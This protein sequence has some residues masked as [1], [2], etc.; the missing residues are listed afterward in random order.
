MSRRSSRWLSWHSWAPAALSLATLV[1]CS[2]GDSQSDTTGEL[3]NPGAAG[4]SGAG[5]GSGGKS[6]GGG[7]PGG[8]GK[9]GGAGQGQ[10]GVGPAG[11]QAGAGQ[12][13]SGQAGSSQTGGQG[14]SGEAG[15]AQG[16]EGG[17]G[18][19]GSGEAGSGQAGSGQ[20]GSGQAGSGQAGSGQAGSGQAGS[21]QAGSGQAGSGQAGSGQAGG[22][23]CCATDADCAGPDPVVLICVQGACE[24]PA[25][26]GSCWQDAECGAGSYCEGETIC[27]CGALCDVADSPGK[28]VPVPDGCCKEDGECA[29]KGL[30]RCLANVCVPALA[31][32]T[33]WAADDCSA[34]QSCEGSTTCP[35][36]ANCVSNPG[37]CADP[38][39]PL[40][41]MTSNDC[42]GEASQCISGVC[43]SLPGAAGQC[44]DETNCGQGQLC[45]GAFICP[46]GADCVPGSDSLGTCVVPG[47]NCCKADAECKP[48]SVCV[49]NDCKPVAPAG[50][51]WGD[52]D[53]AAD[54]TCEGELP[55]ACGVDCKTDQPGKCTPATVDLC[56]KADADCTKQGLSQCVNSVCVGKLTPGTCWDS[57]D[58]KPAQTCTGAFV[59]PCGALCGPVADTPGK[60]T[61]GGALC[62]T[63]DKE[64]G[65]LNECINKVCKPPHSPGACWRDTDCTGGETC[66]GEQ[67]CPCG[68][69]CLVPDQEGKCTPPAVDPCCQVDADCTKQ[70]LSQCVN[71]VCVG[72][73]TA[74]TCWDSNDCKPGQS[75]FGASVCACGALCGPVADTPGKCIDGGGTGACCLKDA[76]CGLGGQCVLPGSTIGQGVCEPLPT[77]KGECWDNGD[78][79][80][81]TKCVGQQVCP[82]GADC[83]LPDSPGKCQ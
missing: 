15:S 25:G 48:G 23:G 28:C 52:A 44:W 7:P 65:G 19:A 10:A 17:G 12:A 1:G 41:C 8:A 81:G 69:S 6:G 18:Q 79:A 5:G 37:K 66:E 24:L 71:N 63:V 29:A 45:Q 13:G 57:N 47:P 27:P 61:D 54:E 4:T 50:Q 59:C 42:P 32:G 35:C 36:G 22:P 31:A 39:P 38:P 70:G 67:I 30:D 49:L 53:C 77:F 9:A 51:C 2:G 43:K 55:C 33:C 75:C 82:C 3:G 58:C 68:S 11:G 72:K 21:G 56:C 16:G 73:L 14:G 76:E 26:N 34:G 83:L 78:C 20:A 62:C 74:G 80:A 46:C 60:C 40:C 64:C